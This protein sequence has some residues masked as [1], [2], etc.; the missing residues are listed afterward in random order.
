M[1]PRLYNLDATEYQRIL[2]MIIIII[3]IIIIT[4]MRS[5]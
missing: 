5:D 3:I 1:E 4:I 2:Y